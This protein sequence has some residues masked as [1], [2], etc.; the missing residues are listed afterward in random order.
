AVGWVT[1]AFGSLGRSIGTGAGLANAALSSA[2]TLIFTADDQTGVMALVSCVYSVIVPS[3]AHL[4]RKIRSASAARRLV[5]PGTTLPSS[6][7]QVLNEAS[8]S[9]MRPALKCLTQVAFRS[10]PPPRF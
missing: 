7:F 6:L 8:A 5:S 3:L 4:P 9:F 2:A 10:A 1:G